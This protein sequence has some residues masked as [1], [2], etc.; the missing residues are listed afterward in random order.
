MKKLITVA[1]LILGFVTKSYTMDKSE[2]IIIYSITSSRGSANYSPTSITMPAG[3]PDD[4]EK[5]ENMKLH[6]ITK[7]NSMMN[8]SAQVMLNIKKLMDRKLQYK[9][10]D[11]NP[12][13]LKIDSDKTDSEKLSW[14]YRK[15]VY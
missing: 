6:A 5:I 3:E 2:T 14:L 13:P 15:D 8:R 4:A 7:S 12:M 1:L 10:K 11:N 9:S